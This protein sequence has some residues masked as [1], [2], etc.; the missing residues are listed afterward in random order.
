MLGLVSRLFVPG[1]ARE[2]AQAVEARLR[3]AAGEVSHELVVTRL[4]RA[5]GERLRNYGVLGK[6]IRHRAIVLHLD[7]PRGYKTDES[8]ERNLMIRKK[9]RQVKV[10]WT[11]HGIVK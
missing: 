6:Q 1:T 4:L 7:H 10:S 9:T 8:I 3:A 2:R 5:I 11:P